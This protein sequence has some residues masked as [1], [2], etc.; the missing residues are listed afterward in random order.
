MNE[1][2]WQGIDLLGWHKSINDWLGWLSLNMFW[3]SLKKWQ[4]TKEFFVQTTNCTFF[5]QIL[6]FPFLFL[7]MTPEIDPPEQ[8]VDENDPSRMRCF[9]RDNPHA[10]LRFSR[11]G[12]QPLP[13]E[14]RDDGRGMLTFPRTQFEHEGD[15]EC[16]A[17]DPTDPNRTPHLS[18]PAKIIVRKSKLVFVAFLRWNFSGYSYCTRVFCWSLE[19]FLPNFGLEWEFY[20]PKTLN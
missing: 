2:V 5:V 19:F 3:T 16:I 17:I 1:R 15:Y 6:N 10:Q 13:P 8:T 18:D 7:V 11:P 4:T 20:A 14:A 12:G 9:V